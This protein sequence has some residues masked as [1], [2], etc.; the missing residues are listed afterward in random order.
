MCK[1]RRTPRYLS[2]CNNFW[3]IMSRLLGSNVSRYD[4]LKIRFG[5]SSLFL[6]PLH[7]NVMEL[8]TV[9]TS[10][11]S[12][13]EFGWH[14]RGWVISC[15][16]FPMQQVEGAEPQSRLPNMPLYLRYEPLLSLIWPTPKDVHLTNNP[17][18]I[19]SCRT[20][21]NSR[22]T[23]T[24]KYTWK[25]S[26]KRIAAMDADD[27][28]RRNQFCSLRSKL[29]TIVQLVPKKQLWWAVGW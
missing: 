29:V 7:R 25:T 21:K 15:L 5:H 18:P 16:H 17:N 22:I 1:E 8:C 23:L 10:R 4:F 14:L 2:N 3:P 13:I 24:E 28:D 12:S 11:R 19:L 9:G 26:R 27:P 20:S 6:H